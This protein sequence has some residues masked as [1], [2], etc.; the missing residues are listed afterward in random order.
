MCFY[1]FH[2]NWKYLAMKLFLY[3]CCLVFVFRAVSSY[4][5]VIRQP[6]CL[7][8][9]DVG[10]CEDSIK[11]YGYDYTTNRCVHF[12][13]GGCGGNPNRFATKEECMQECHVESEESAEDEEYILDD[14]HMRSDL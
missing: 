6:K 13:Y 14:I 1:E 4:N 7:Y 2:F 9:A 5:K 12:F 3:I 10:P 11:V 8:M